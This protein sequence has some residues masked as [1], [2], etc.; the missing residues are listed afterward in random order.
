MGKKKALVIGC[1]IAG[2][3]VAMFLRRAGVEPHLFEAKAEPDDYAGLFLNVARNGLHV[4]GELG[5]DARIRGAGIEMRAMSFASSSGKLLGTVGD[6]AGPPQGIT[7]KRG[8]LHRVL[9]E[10]AEGEGIPVAFGKRLVD[11]RNE[12][13][14]VTAVFA[15]GTSAEGDFLVGCDGIHSR[16]RRLL[17]PDAPEPSYTGLISFG[18]FSRGVRVSGR[19]GIQHMVF[20]RKAFF[21]YI[22]AP[23]GEIYW[24]G[25]LEYPGSPTRR[26]L[27]AIPQAEWR[28]LV[29]DLYGRERPTVPDIIRGTEGEIG[30]Y[31]ICDLMSVPR[32][33]DGA[34]VLIGDAIHATSPNAGQGASMALEDALVLAKCV[35]D[36]ADP[37]EAFRRFEAVRRER[38]ERIV[39]ASRA[40]GR[41]KHAKHPVQAFFRDLLMPVFL[42]MAGRQSDGWML[43][44]RETWRD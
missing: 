32:W 5:V 22:A 14:G 35:R 34:A 8:L 4:L 13:G 41:Q 2:P 29:D 44:F 18:G 38:V 27:M 25:N 6:D 9:R 10:A 24:F 37:G 17:I 39:R 43:D 11:L 33:H 42:K 40:I 36:A 7:V 16:V 30:V 12:R 21:G 26:D 19:T 20:G 15:D 23:D 28:R 31:P 1:G 3:A